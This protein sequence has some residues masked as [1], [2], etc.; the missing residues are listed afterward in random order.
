M[1]RFLAGILTACLALLAGTAALAD[2]DQNELA[3]ASL[4]QMS[5]MFFTDMWGN[6][7]ADLDVRTML[8]GY[9]TV[10][11][12]ADGNFIIDSTA[13]IDTQVSDDRSGNRTYT[14][15]LSDA[16]RY[17]DGTPITAKDYV[18]NVLLR[19]CP[20]VAE[21]NGMNQAYNHLLG[22]EAFAQ[23]QPFSGVRLLDEHRFSL[24]IKRAN[25]P[26]FYELHMIDAW[27]A[28]LAVIAPGCDVVDEGQ[29]AWIQGGERPFDAALLR[30][31]LMDPETGYLSHPARTSGPYQ[32]VAYD[33]VKREAAFEINPHY[34]G[35]YAGQKPAIQ[36]VTF[37]WVRL[38]TMFDDL[39]SGRIDLINKVTDGEAIA[40]GMQLR[41]ADKLASSS[42]PRAGLN[43]LAFACE[44]PLTQSVHMRKAIMFCLDTMALCDEFLKGFGMPVYGYYGLGQWMAQDQEALNPLCRYSFSLNAAANMLQTDGWI[45]DEQGELFAQREGAVRYKRME[46]GTL[47]PLKLRCALPEEGALTPYLETMLTQNLASIGGQIECVKLPFPELLAQYYRQ[48]ARD[49]D[50]MQV[51][52]NFT[53]VFDP[54]YTFHTGDE[55][56]GVHNTTGL[57]DEGLMA[58]ADAM[59][60]VPPGDLARYQEQWMAFQDAWMELLPMAPLY[61]NAYFDF[62][63]LKLQNYNITAQSNWSAALLYAYIG[64][65]P[66]E[67]EPDT[68]SAEPIGSPLGGEEVEFLD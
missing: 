26:N 2:V 32:L 18:F 29:G 51:A 34:L 30:E 43:M 68:L 17:N 33:A 65:P 58:R 10:A 62:Y 25:L 40:Q 27:P 42:Y 5:G 14:F 63:H 4:T 55:Y 21:L 15:T 59:R 49:F 54:F 50:I 44:R 16:L 61:S 9:G 12:A 37:G 11:W 24:T 45:Y 6:N 36:R 22:Y 47:Q 23:G 56:Q 38:D 28:P 64:D 48:S 3:V 13:V 19:S 35:N 1:K 67:T 53:Q 31:T 66:A 60:R 20:Q 52:T 7:S 39:T 41:G 57:R 8:H 46:D